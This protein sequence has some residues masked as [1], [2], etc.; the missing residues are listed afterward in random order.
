MHHTLDSNLP[1]FAY[2]LMISEGGLQLQLPVDD[3]HGVRLDPDELTLQLMVAEGQFSVRFQALLQIQL[4]NSEHTS[5]Y[6][7]PLIEGFGS[8]VV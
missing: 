3:P 5:E 2:L 6:F 1:N 4:Y 8:I 7:D